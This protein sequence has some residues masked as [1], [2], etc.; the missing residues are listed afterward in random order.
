M[1]YSIYRF[2]M[3]GYYEYTVAPSLLMIA[4]VQHSVDL[5]VGRADHPVIMVAITYIFVDFLSYLISTY[6]KIGILELRAMTDPLTGLYNRSYL[7]DLRTSEK[8]AVIFIDIDGFKEIND[9][10]GHAYGDWVLKTFAKIVKDNIK[11]KDVALR[12]GGDEFVIILRDCVDCWFEI[13][14]GIRREFLR[15]TGCDISYGY[16]PGGD[17]V[18]ES[19]RIA[20]E[21]MYKMKF[22]KKTKQRT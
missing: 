6:K 14:E 2:A 18:I 10:K 3:K 19:L 5:S 12:Y 22:S 8:D 21:K 15:V 9:T 7:A 4:V 20:D 16:H 13:V 17:D 11:G 1:G